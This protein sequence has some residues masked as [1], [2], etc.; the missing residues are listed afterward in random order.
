MKKQAGFSLI[1]IMIAVAIIGFLATTVGSRVMTYMEKARVSKTKSI[2]VSL[3][4]LVIEYATDIGHPPSKKEGG[5]EALV[6][7]PS[8]EA[9]ARW[10]EPYISEIP[11]DGWGHE[12][13]YN[14]P[15]KIFTKKF[16]RFEIYSMGKKDE[17]DED[18]AAGE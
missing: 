5:L 8:G 17:E 12:F 4:Q 3:K 13:E 11:R 7:K 6:Q 1:E 14:C 15:P 16:K 10:K 2:L 9:G 18:L